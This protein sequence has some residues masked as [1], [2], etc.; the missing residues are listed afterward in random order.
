[1]NSRRR[2]SSAPHLRRISCPFLLSLPSL[3]TRANVKPSLSKLSMAG[4]TCPAPR[5]TTAINPPPE[6]YLLSLGHHEDLHDFIAQVIANLHCDAAVF[7]L[8]KR[9]RNV[10]VEA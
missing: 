8:G 7:R 1:M 6:A 4:A 3:G 2:R 9:T 5:T 10:T